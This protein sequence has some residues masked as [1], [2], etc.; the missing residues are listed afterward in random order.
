MSPSTSLVSGFRPQLLE[1][2]ARLQAAS[3]AV[4]ADY[5]HDLI[6]EVDAALGRIER[7]SFGLCETCHEAIEGDRLARNPL[8]RFCLD[9]L[10]Q[11]ELEAHQQDLELASEIQSK[12]L[13]PRGFALENWDTQ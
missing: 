5:L 13:P 10:S 6:T 9:H 4:S 3:D 11:A 7:G 2:R 8:L 1:R 12:L